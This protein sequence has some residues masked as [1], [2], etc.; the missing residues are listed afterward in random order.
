MTYP[1]FYKNTTN[2]NSN[3]VIIAFISTFALN[4]T[5]MAQS[6]I[7]KRKPKNKFQEEAEKEKEKLST[8]LQPY[9][10]TQTDIEL[11]IQS[12]IQNLSSPY[13]VERYIKEISKLQGEQYVKAYNEFF[14]NI[15][16]PFLKITQKDKDKNKPKLDAFEIIQE[17]EE[18]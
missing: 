11:N 8:E 16:K 10:D 1:F 13:F 18:D 17:F 12:V 7:I 14:K 4:S 6:K 5:N 2:E 3:I 15:A 9:T